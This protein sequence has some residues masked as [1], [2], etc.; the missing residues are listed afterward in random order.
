M[1]L[2]RCSKITDAGI[3][4]LLSLPALEKLCISETG[5]TAV[6]VASL[7]ALTNLLFLDLGGLPVSDSALSSLK[8]ENM[9]SL[10]LSLSHAA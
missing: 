4:H 7:A 8:V 9:C 2:S 5:V 1:D 3:R 6:G 10:S